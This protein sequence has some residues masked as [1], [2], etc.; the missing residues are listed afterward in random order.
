MRDLHFNKIAE[1]GASAILMF[2]Y[3]RK[4]YMLKL[5]YLM[6]SNSLARSLLSC[7]S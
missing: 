2:N 5:I 3:M 7:S 1:A 6:D 4:N